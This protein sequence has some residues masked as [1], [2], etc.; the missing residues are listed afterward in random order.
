MRLPTII[1]VLCALGILAC[2]TTSG[3]HVKKSRYS[4]DNIYFEE[5]YMS[6]AANAYDLIRNSHPHWLQLREANSMSYPIVFL[7]GFRYGGIPDLRT[8]ATQHI[9]EIQFFNAA[10]AFIRFGPDCPGGAILVT[11][12]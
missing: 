9:S 10:D 7:D 2:S 4:R 8:I 12:N 1:T 11:S 3:T 5:I 6:R